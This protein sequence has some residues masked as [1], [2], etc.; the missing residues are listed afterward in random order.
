[1]D[2]I[3]DDPNEDGT[4]NF[5]EILNHE[6]P[7]RPG[8]QNYR[9]SAWNVLVLWETG[10]ISWEPLNE[11]KV[12]NK[13]SCALYGKKHNL[14]D[15]PGW[16]QFKSIANRSKHMMRLVN[17]AK[18]Q[19]FRVTPVYMYGYQVPRN[20][21]QAMELDLKNGNTK[22]RDS[23]I[24]ELKQILEYGTFNDM[25]RHGRAPSGYKKI[26][27][28]FVY[29]VKHDGRHK[30]RLVAG[31]H[32]TATPIDSVYSSVVSLRGV[33]MVVFLAELNGLLVWATDIGNAYLK[34]NTAK[35]VYII[36]GP[37]FGP[38]LEG[39]TLIIVK[40]LYGLKSSG[41]RWWEVLAD[42]LRQM[43]FF[44]SYAKRDIWMRDKGDHYEY[45]VVYVDN[46]AIAS[47]DPQS[48]IDVLMGDFK[49]KLKGTGP[50]AFH[51]GCDY[52][53]DKDGVLCFAPKKYI[54]KLSESYFRHFG[55]K[56]K[57]AS[58]PLE[59]GDHPEMDTSKE[60][61]LE[62]IKIYQSLV[63]ALQWAIQIGRLDITTAVMT[64]SSFRTN[65]QKG[66][67]D[68]VKRICGYLLKMRNATIRFRTDEPDYSNLP[69]NDYDWD[70]SVY[71]G[72]TE[73]I[74]ST[75][76]RPLGKRVTTSTYYDANL[77]HDMIS[78][79]SVTGI[80]HFFNKT[81]ID[82]FSKKQATVKTATF[83]SEFVAGR[84]A[85]EQ[86]ID[87]RLTLRYLG[88]PIDGPTYVFGDNKTTVDASSLPSCTL[89]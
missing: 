75:M 27:V 51:L 41:Q 37:E 46:L 49:F 56:P 2:L 29:A 17:Q 1:M 35:L 55:D 11:F 65:P 19:S 85:V 72:A 15:Q 63:G 84:T 18:L 61:D 70:M 22:W 16:K 73:E 69:P 53:R 45:I 6:G 28:H 58:S 57:P 47:K 40:A 68:R 87:L 14:L 81:P 76:P 8:D 78:G 5:L 13:A 26:K 42:C 12:N 9:N 54:M 39:H 89:A 24:L 77:Y 33:R 25:G 3:N 67:L 7:L 62:G 86:I 34:S 43:N 23:E 32:L 66:H 36:A 64:M 44:P 10:E 50:L 21:E 74:P 83:G 88:V 79:K 80:L 71:K 52:F 48:I 38:L 59:K 20:H 60:L 4:W 82:W 30:A 31:G